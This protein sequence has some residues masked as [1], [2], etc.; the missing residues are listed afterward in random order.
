[1]SDNDGEDVAWFMSFSFFSPVNVCG[2]FLLPG[3]K[4]ASKKNNSTFFGK[5]YRNVLYSFVNLRV[6]NNDYTF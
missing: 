5:S 4:E 6:L 3:L 2:F 1:M